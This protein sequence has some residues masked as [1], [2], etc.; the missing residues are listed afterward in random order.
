MRVQ[1]ILLVN[2]CFMLEKT[3]LV[4]N[5]RYLNAVLQETIERD[6]QGGYKELIKRDEVIINQHPSGSSSQPG[7]SCDFRQK[8]EDS[9]QEST[10]SSEFQI[11]SDSDSEE[12]P[13]IISLS[14]ERKKS[15]D[16]SESSSGS[17]SGRSTL[18]R[19]EGSA[20]SYS[21]ECSD[22]SSESGSRESLSSTDSE[23]TIEARPV[24]APNRR[25]IK[26]SGNSPTRSCGTS[27]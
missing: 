4:R 21:N 17:Y 18:T 6:R 27:F 13:R 3:Y 15:W 2:F 23:E 26:S 10:S 14:K 7:K 19:S 24:E 25:L 8:T 16:N 5:I 12:R 11:T 1:Q 9:S 20:E 22:S